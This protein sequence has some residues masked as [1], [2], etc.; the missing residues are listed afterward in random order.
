M[1]PA[2]V[3]RPLGH[4]VLIV[5]TICVVDEIIDPLSGHALFFPL[6]GDHI[7]RNN[8]QVGDEDVFEYLV[9]EGDCVVLKLVN[10]ICAFLHDISDHLRGHGPN[11]SLIHI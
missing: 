9:S 5:V 8:S 10:G 6:A 4:V 2:G 3:L 11:L 1:M 7:V